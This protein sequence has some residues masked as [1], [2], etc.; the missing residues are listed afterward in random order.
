MT[1]P[2]FPKAIN[3]GFGFKVPIVWKNKV[4]NSAGETVAGAYTPVADGPPIIELDA[5]EPLWDQL[6]LF[7]HEVIHAA[8]DFHRHLVL[9]AMDIRAEAAKEEVLKEKE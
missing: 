4:K 1:R 9:Q 6:D 5:T 7:G 2:R 8:I 3:F